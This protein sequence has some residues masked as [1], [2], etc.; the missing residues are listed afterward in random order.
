[1]ETAGIKLTSAAESAIIISLVPV[2]AMIAAM[3]IL[4]EIPAKLQVVFIVL[5]VLGAIVIVIGNRLSSP[6]FNALGY[7]ALFGAV[8]SAVSFIILSRHVKN[9]SSAAK[10]Y[11][12]LGMGFVFFTSAAAIE[13][14]YNG[15]TS[16][17][18]TLPFNNINFLISLLILGAII[19][20][21]GS[22]GMNFSIERLGVS[23]SSAFLGITTLVSVVAGMYILKEPFT[24]ATGI[25]MIMILIGVTGVNKFARK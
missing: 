8:I 18:L 7:L 6:T 12:M 5:S 11:V 16:L 22:W 4:K 13:N 14:I 25:G 15:T 17:W 10:T 24:L 21:F 9:Y 19:S 23:R 3:L 20:V 2:F 1:M